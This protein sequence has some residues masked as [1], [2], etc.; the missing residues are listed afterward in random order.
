MMDSTAELE[1]M[2]ATVYGECAVGKNCFRVD[3]P[4]ALAVNACDMST[5]YL[6]VYNYYWVLFSIVS[7]LPSY[8]PS[9]FHFRNFTYVMCR[10]G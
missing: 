2:A 6:F 3:L 7:H 9:Y 5:S 8:C 10:K 4:L 1:D